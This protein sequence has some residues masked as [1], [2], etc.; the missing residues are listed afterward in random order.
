MLVL[1]LI[2]RGAHGLTCGRLVPDSSLLL[3]CGRLGLCLGLL[4]LLLSRLLLVCKS[5]GLLLRYGCIVGSLIVFVSS[6]LAHVDDLDCLR[7]IELR[8]HHHGVITL[9]ESASILLGGCHV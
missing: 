6:R 2:L 8:L 5:L 4:L 9:T 1:A 3:L 7:D